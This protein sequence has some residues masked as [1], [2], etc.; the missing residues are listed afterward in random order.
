MLVRLNYPMV[1]GII[2]SF[3]DV[4][5]E[6]R[7]NELTDQVKANS[8]FRKTDDLFFSGETYEVKQ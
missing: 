4:T 8:N 3:D 6:E 2:R 1:M 5:L 7:E